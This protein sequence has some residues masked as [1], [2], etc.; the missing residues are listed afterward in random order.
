[1]VASVSYL[2]RQIEPREW[3]VVALEAWRAAGHRGVVE[4]VTGAGK[5]IFAE[6]CVAAYVARTQQPRVLIYVPTLAL[7]D[8]WVVSLVDD[9]GLGADQVAVYTGRSRPRTPALVNVFTINTA[10]THAASVSSPGALL[11]VDECH[12]A[13]SPANARA[14]A[15][16]HGATLGLSATPEREYD[17]GFNE[18]VVPSLGHIIYT[19][20]YAEARRD[21]VIAPFRLI[22]VS[23]PLLDKE[24]E[25]YQTFS[26]RIARLLRTVSA[27]DPHL[28]RILLARARLVKSA[29]LRAPVAVRLVERHPGV[30]VIVFHEQVAAAELISRNLSARG[31][32]AAVYHSQ[33]SDVLRQ[34]NL[35][36]FRRGVFQVLVTC[37]ALDEGMNVP[38]TAVAVIAS[39]SASNRQR[40]QRLG[41]ILRPHST[42]EQALVYTL[43]ATDVEEQRLR[44]EV[45]SIG[46]ESVDWL[47]SGLQ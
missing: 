2:G 34:D 46:A 40:I 44:R 35:R 13:G 25:R 33:M 20:G 26:R 5:T 3:Q 32:N 43:Y 18:L 9:M 4:V 24:Q 38:E 42:K 41:R 16:D 47:K 28:E 23:V 21:G 29:A 1:M 36:L 39:S 8:Q 10:R 22:N 37:R 30:R 17:A 11:I 19:Y 14:L 31:R 45:R 6:L 27:D 7:V 12:R 15:V